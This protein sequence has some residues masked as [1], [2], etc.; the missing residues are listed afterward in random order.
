MGKSYKHRQDYD[1]DENELHF[2][3]E[4]KRLK[5]ALRTKDIDMFYEDEDDEIT[6]ESS[7]EYD[8]YL[9]YKKQNSSEE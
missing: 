9:E 1:D 3:K 8:A 4:D 5:R 7:P 2:E 6:F